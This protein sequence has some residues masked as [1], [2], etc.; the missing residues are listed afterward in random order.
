MA[1]KFADLLLRWS[2]SSSHRR[3]VRRAGVV[4]ELRYGV[5]AA[6]APPRSDTNVIPLIN[7]SEPINPFELINHFEPMKT[8]RAS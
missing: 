6:S 5:F 8:I 2:R 3:P 4:H 1:Y 7:T